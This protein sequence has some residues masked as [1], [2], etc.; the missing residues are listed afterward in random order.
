MYCQ[1]FLSYF[2]VLLY[3]VST[4]K[5]SQKCLWKDIR[6]APIINPVTLNPNPI[7]KP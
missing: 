7:P 1:Q 2:F 4:E 5:V 3:T 6:T